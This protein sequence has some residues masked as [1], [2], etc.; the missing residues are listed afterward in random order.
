MLRLELDRFEKRE[1]RKRIYIERKEMVAINNLT[2]IGSH[3]VIIF[4]A[5]L[6]IYL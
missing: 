1:M 4:S 5:K 6:Y 3:F 2:I